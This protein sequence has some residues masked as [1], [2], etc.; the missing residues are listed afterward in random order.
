M[1]TF[2][3][4]SFQWM[5]ILAFIITVV[6]FTLLRQEFEWVAD[7]PKIKIFIYVLGMAIWLVS[8][9]IIIPLTKI[10]IEEDKIKEMY[11]KLDVKEKEIDKLLAFLKTKALKATFVSRKEV[12]EHMGWEYKEESL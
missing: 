5:N 12:C 7:P 10:T 2:M 8:W 3:L 11:D 9:M 4:K 1:R 6:G